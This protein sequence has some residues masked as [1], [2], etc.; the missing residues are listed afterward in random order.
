[1]LPMH[2]SAA[3]KKRGK[4]LRRKDKVIACTSNRQFYTYITREE[5]NHYLQVIESVFLH[6]SN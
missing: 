2:K 6:G 1:M 5:Q 4:W 3:W